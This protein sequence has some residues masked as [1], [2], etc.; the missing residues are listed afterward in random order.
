MG[1]YHMPKYRSTKDL[2]HSS[3]E[4][5][6]LNK[7]KEPG[8]WNKV[9]NIIKFEQ[10]KRTEYLQQMKDKEKDKTIDI[11]DELYLCNYSLDFG[12]E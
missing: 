12:S 7:Y 9:I 8:N 1:C 2:A 3:N 6:Y 11:F 10:Q 4:R 5:L